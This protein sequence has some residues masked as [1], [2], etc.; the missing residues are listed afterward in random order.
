MIAVIIATLTLPRFFVTDKENI[1]VADP[2]YEIEVQK[3]VK[4]I[5]KNDSAKQSE[6]KVNKQG[7]KFHPQQFDPNTATISDYMTMGFSEKQSAVLVRYREKG[8]VFHKPEDFKRMY[9]IDEKTYET[10]RPFIKIADQAPPEVD[11]PDQSIK[12]TKKFAITEINSADSIRLLEIRGVGPVFASRI[13]KYRSRLGGFV[14]TDQLQEVYG[15]DSVRFE[16]IKPQVTVDTTLVNKI[17]F[18]SVSL[19]ELRRHPYMNY[20]RAKAII[21]KR[22]RQKGFSST[23]D[24]E[25]VLKKEP[26]IFGKLKPYIKI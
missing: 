23:E 7:I 15:I 14:S 8:G 5:N 11:K 19:E 2:L 1:S 20:Y 10:F 13:I 25:H 21:D 17:D 26:S 18:N 12:S 6:I 3:F 22:I 4:A 24:I 16:S 9:I